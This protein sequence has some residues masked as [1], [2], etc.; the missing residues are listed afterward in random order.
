LGGFSPKGAINIPNAPTFESKLTS[1]NIPVPR[2][3][4]GEP[5]ELNQNESLKPMSESCTT[6]SVPVKNVAPPEVKGGDVPAAMSS[7]V[8]TV[9][10]AVCA[11]KVERLVMIVDACSADVRARVQSTILNMQLPLL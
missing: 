5:A 3:F 1:Q 7:N 11:S 8:A 2:K 6:P 9:F 4:G 10:E